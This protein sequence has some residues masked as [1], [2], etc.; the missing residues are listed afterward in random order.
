MA[1]SRYPGPL[2]QA[3]LAE[4]AQYVLTDP[5]PFVIDLPKCHGMFLATTDGR[6][7]FDWAGHY[8]SKLIAHNHPALYEPEYTRRLVCAANNKLPNPDMLTP[9]CLAY[10]RELHALAPASMRN[11]PGARLEVYS[12]NSGAEAVENLMKYFINLHHEKLLAKGRLPGV[13]RFI[14]FEQAFHGRTVFA[15]NV[16]Q[17]EHDPMITKDFHGFVPGN[18]QLPFPAID[19]DAPPAEL[20]ADVE[21]CLELVEDC[22]RRYRGEVVGM[23]VEPIQGAGGHR[24][25]PASFFQGLSRLAHAHDVYLG[26]DEVQTAGGQTGSFFA[27]EQFDL[28]H[29]PQAVAC[30][31][32][33]G[34]GV[35]YM[36]N[37]MTDRGVLDSTWGG[38]LAD[39]VRFVQE[40]RVVREE[41]L[42]EQVP[43]KTAALVAMLRGLQAKHPGKLCNVRGLGLYQGFSLREPGQKSELIEIAL[44][45]H[46]VLFLGAGPDS[47]R[48]RPHLNV[49]S[50]DIDELGRRLDAAL[51]RVGQA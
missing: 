28:P 24:V 40:M 33:L 43:A 38:T 6:E 15:L 7:L 50:A 22:L 26:F 23:V 17:I 39:M 45:E 44:E 4:L 47:V 32:K 13:R 41:Q 5:Y 30:G 29:P 12:I 21:K 34:N 18:M 16:T 36:K 3:A 49:T 51:A 42:L 8:A 1:E 37:P 2:A 20:A 48:L 19:S 31:K 46:D 35:I 27:F 9:E 10:Y 14:Y 25:A 11:A